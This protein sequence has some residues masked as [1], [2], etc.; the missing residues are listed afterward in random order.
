MR[1]GLLEPNKGYIYPK[2]QK[3]TSYLTVRRPRHLLKDTQA[4]WN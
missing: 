3:Q 1:V 2:P 4:H